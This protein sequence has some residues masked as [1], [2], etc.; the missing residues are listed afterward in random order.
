MEG[1]WPPQKREIVLEVNRWDETPYKIGDTVLIQLSSGEVRGLSL[2]GI[3]QDQ[4][5]GADRG[6]AG[7][8]LAPIQGYVTLDTLPWLKLT[9]LFNTL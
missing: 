5:L 3:V 9:D 2:V 6:G 4:T 7:F 1:V 8:F